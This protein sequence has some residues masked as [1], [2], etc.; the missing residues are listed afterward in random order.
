MGTWIEIAGYLRQHIRNKSFPSWERGLK[1]WGLGSIIR[2]TPVVPLVGTWIEI[3]KQFGMS[4]LSF[5]VPL[6]GTWIEILRKGYR[7]CAWKV[8]PLVGTW[9]EIT[10]RYYTFNRNRVVPLVGTWIEMIILSCWR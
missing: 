5:V 2:C 6:V 9:I 1:S 8:V 3:I 4:E 7:R 10:K